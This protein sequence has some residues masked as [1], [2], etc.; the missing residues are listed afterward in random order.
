MSMPGPLSPFPFPAPNSAA[1]PAPPILPQLSPFDELGV[2]RGKAFRSNGETRD[3]T[4][5][6]TAINELYAVV[7]SSSHDWEYAVQLDAIPRQNLL[8]ILAQADDYAT[9]PTRRLELARILMLADRLPEAGLLLQ[10]AA[11]DFP[12]L[13][14]R[15]GTADSAGPRTACRSHHTGPR[16]T[17]H[18]RPA[19]AGIQRRRTSSQIRPDPGDHR[20]SRTHRSGL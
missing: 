11:N 13:Q 6:I 19:S 10:N 4:A 20:S 18:G 9:N 16:R 14:E 12:Q 15:G 17:P 8:N 5:A 1:K 7:T 3:V 2:A